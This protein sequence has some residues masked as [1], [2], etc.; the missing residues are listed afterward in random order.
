MASFYLLW[1]LILRK[2]QVHLEQLQLKRIPDRSLA[3]AVVL[4][5]QQP[6]SHLQDLFKM[7]SS[8][9]CPQGGRLGGSGIEL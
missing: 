9:L 5:L 8:G 4:R 6:V 3:Q 7:Q 1:M 2:S